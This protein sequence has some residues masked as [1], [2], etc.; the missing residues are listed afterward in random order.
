MNTTNLELI[1]IDK[2]DP[3]IIY[4]Q[5]VSQ[6]NEDVDI[7]SPILEITPPN[8]STR[9][10]LIYPDSS[11]IPI[12]SNALGWTLASSYEELTVLVD[13][14]WL[15]KQ[16]VKP[17]DCIYKTHKHFR[18]VNLKKKIFCYVAEQLDY[19]APNCNITDV[20]YEDI[21]KLLTLLD[22]AKYLAE[23][24]DKCE[25]AKIIYNQ[26]SNMFKKYSCNSGC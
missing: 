13:G 14:L 17:N 21:Y 4:I 26:V 11:I 18:I 23:E 12:N 1:F 15:F 3:K 8:Y 6:Y 20:W 25:E 10:S 7:E 2:P 19:S 5:D 9:Y 24:C 22:S 16:S